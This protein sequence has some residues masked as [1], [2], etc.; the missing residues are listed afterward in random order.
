M[1]DEQRAARLEMLD[2]SLINIGLHVASHTHRFTLLAWYDGA[3]E[4]PF[5]ANLYDEF[6]YQYYGHGQSLG[7]ALIDL[8][9]N[10]PE[11]AAALREIREERRPSAEVQPKRVPPTPEERT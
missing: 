1:L 3:N 9:L 4:P 8:A 11:L 6:G 2:A 10:A 5:A 7:T